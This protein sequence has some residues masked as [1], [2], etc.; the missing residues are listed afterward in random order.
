[1]TAAGTLPILSVQGVSKSVD[2][3][4]VLANVSFT[5]QRDEKVVFVSDDSQKTTLMLEILAG[6]VQPDTGT[7]RWG[8][9]VKH[10]YFPKDHGSYFQSN[11][12]LIDWLRRYSVDQSEA[13][14]R[15][16]LGRM[17]FKGEE[18]MKPTAALSGGEA[19]RLIFSKL[20]LTKDN[21]L[22]LDEPTNHLDLES[23]LAL[24]D[25]LEKYEGTCFVVTHDR[26]LVSQFATRIWAF[27]DQ[28]LVDWQGNYDD[29]VERFGGESETTA[30]GSD[31][32]DQRSA[33]APA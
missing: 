32:D 2:G 5:V 18:G 31:R 33:A 20:M 30:S 1:M 22:V 3:A 28:G 21:V 11:L 17:L 25:A 12:D 15:T 10:S 7:V 4:P 6:A 14:V 29:F 8:G 13:F 24:G 23:I 26:D 27:T 19:V 16:F 9:S